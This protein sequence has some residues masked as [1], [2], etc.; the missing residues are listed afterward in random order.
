MSAKVHEHYDFLISSDLIG[1]RQK[2]KRLHELNEAIRFSILE[3]VMEMLIRTG[4][5]DSMVEKLVK[6]ESDPAS[7]AEEIARKYL[8]GCF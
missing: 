6:K 1:D 5:L 3:P 7:L 4:E 8:Q 2:R